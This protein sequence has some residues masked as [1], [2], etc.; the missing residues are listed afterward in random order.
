MSHYNLGAL[1]KLTNKPDDALKEFEIATMLNPNLAGPH[2]QL[3]NSY[4]TAGRTADAAREQQIFQD[5]KKKQ[6][7]AAVAED[8]EWSYYAEIYDITDPNG[9]VETQPAKELKF[10]TAKLSDGF[11]A[12][13]A[14]LATADIDGDGNPEI[15][16][17]SA[18]GVKIFK[19]GSA[20]DAGLDGLKDVI[21]IT[22]GDF[23]ND[24]LADL[25]VVTKTGA[26]LWTNQKGKFAKSTV[27][28]PDGHYAKAIWLDYDHDYDLDLF[29]LGDKSILLRNNGTAGFSDESK[30][31]PFVAATAV[32]AAVSDVTPDTDG[33]D[34][35]VA[36]KG[37]VGVL[38]RDKLAGK[39]AAEDLTDVPD[40]A[41]A[42]ASMDL[43]NDGATDLLV[44][45]NTG[46]FPLLNNKAGF[47][48]GDVLGKTGVATLADVETRGLE[49]V[50]VS[51]TVFRNEGL[52]KFTATK[53]AAIGDS[54][55][56]TSID[57]NLA[58]IQRDGSLMVPAQYD[59]TPATKYLRATLQGVKNLKLAY[60]AKDRSQ[61][62]A[63]LSEAHLLRHTDHFRH[64]RRRR[65]RN[66]PH[67]M[68]KR[69]DPERNSSGDRQGLHV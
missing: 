20:V 12:A 53:A 52:G 40:G 61:S 31:F 49:D 1:Y 15:I 67:L 43:N 10:D 55:A 13:T 27:A 56:L 14:G 24:G 32:D 37:H 25:A 51:G 46:V 63:P 8:L 29:V 9:A 22:P 3:A 11:D 41:L 21:S 62:G 48:K 16:A 19:N 50:V 54:V 33:M 57:N 45:T 23:N 64:A 42:V 68:G 18:N 26:E 59:R 58:E 7:G 38:Y 36:Y 5:I 69:T 34:L 28:I 6:Q 47:T 60:G 39:Y 30:S 2:F 65:S 35:V 4:R 66:R 44:S 17:W